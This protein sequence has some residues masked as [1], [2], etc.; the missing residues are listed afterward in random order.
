MDLDDVGRQCGEMAARVLKGED[1]KTINAEYPRKT[2]VA[3]N[4]KTA[5]TM[6]LI[7]SPDV[8]NLAN[9]IYHDW[10]GKEVTRKS[11]L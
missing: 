10:D 7:F 1:I 8:L 3:L 4:R 2:L 6:G 5:D 9:V 11:G